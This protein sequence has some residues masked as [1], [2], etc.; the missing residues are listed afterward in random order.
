M[1][2]IINEAEQIYIKLTNQ[3]A[4]LLDYLREQKTA[5]IHG[6]AGTGKT[7]FAKEKAR[8]L[9]EEGENVLFLCYNSFLKDFLRKQ[10][11]QPGIIFHNA[12]SLAVEILKDENIGVDELVNE[13]EEYLIEV[14]EPEDWP[15][16]HIVIDEGQDLNERLVNRLKRNLFEL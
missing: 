11:S 14:F 6:L 4:A 13:L 15:Y 2:G 8:M 12:H 7:V 9:A 1:K 3:Q 16:S 5:V 10:F